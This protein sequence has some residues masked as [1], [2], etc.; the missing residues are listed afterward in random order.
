MVIAEGYEAGAHLR[1]KLHYPAHIPVPLVQPS[2]VEGKF[3]YYEEVFDY[4]HLQ[5]DPPEDRHVSVF[6]E[7]IASVERLDEFG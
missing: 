2:A 7:W 1:L 4:W 3:L 6:G 5:L